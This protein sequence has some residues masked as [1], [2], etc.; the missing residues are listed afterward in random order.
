MT[1]ETYPASPFR[2]PLTARWEGITNHGLRE[3]SVPVLTEI[4]PGLWQGGTRNGLILPAQISHLVSLYS[5]QSYTVEHD[6]A[7][8]LTVRM[9]D[10]AGQ[11]L[12]AVDQIARWVAACRETGPV[13]VTCQAGLNRSGLIVARVLMLGG[14]T[15]DAA[16]SLIREKRDPACLCNPAFEAWLRGQEQAQ[17]PRAACPACG[18]GILR[19]GD[20]RLRL[21]AARVPRGPECPGSGRLPAEIP[22]AAS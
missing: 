4:A 9:A 1:T 7:S 2:D 18:R 19:N 10:S 17:S 13:A 6:L 22:A 15:A 8:H 11:S 12:A 21:H 16:I 3:V 20:G 14:M 5:S